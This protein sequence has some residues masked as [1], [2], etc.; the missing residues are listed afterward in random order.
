M[1]EL[2][3]PEELMASRHDEELE[4]ALALSRTITRREDDDLQ[5]A[6][7]ASELMYQEELKTQQLIEQ[8]KAQQRQ[9]Q[10]QREKEQRENEER[11]QREQKEKE[12]REQVQREREEKE[13][14]EKQEKEQREKEEK[15]QREREEKEQREREEKAQRE[16]EQ[17]E[18]EQRDKEQRDKEQ[19]EKEQRDK[20]EQAR[21][22]KEQRELLDKLEKEQKEQ[23]KLKI[24]DDVVLVPSSADVD[25]EM[26][27]ERKRQR[28]SPAK[29]NQEALRVKEEAQLAQI[30]RESLLSYEAEQRARQLDDE[31]KQG[32]EK[33]RLEQER[34]ANLEI[35]ER[36]RLQ[37]SERA[38]REREEDLNQEPEG[39]PPRDLAIPAKDND[40]TFIT[41][42]RRLSQ[43]QG[44]PPDLDLEN[45]RL[46]SPKLTAEEQE[47]AAIL[48]ASHDM[49]VE[50]KQLQAKR[51]HE[52]NEPPQVTVHA[53]VHP[54]CLWSLMYF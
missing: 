3:F 21:R 12:A 19:R 37:K 41:A 31:L 1:S 26:H 48:R 32:I 24:D 13:Q 53:Q 5:S 40:R 29:P 42:R 45:L 16:K 51:L 6:L 44:R 15:E 38:R 20:E 8:A 9:E 7:A 23:A 50:S 17:R 33:E 36:D 54:L 4:R 47:R 14:R 46:G 27:A 10:E 30:F 22:E 25:R 34:Q 28:L 39:Q 52:A 2:K 49:L 43:D 35:L 11:Q 18:K